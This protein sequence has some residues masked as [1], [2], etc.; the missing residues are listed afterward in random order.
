MAPTVGLGVFKKRQ[1]CCFRLESAPNL[2]TVPD[3]LFRLRH[4]VWLYKLIV[5]A[6]LTKLN[7][8]PMSMR[9]C[10]NC[11]GLFKMESL[12]LVWGCG[13]WDEIRTGLLL[14]RGHGVAQLVEALRYKPEGRGFDS[15]LYHW[16]F[17]LT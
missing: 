8:R 12:Y 9:L 16:N 13:K 1:I 6:D 4:D 2:V 15:R 10:A 3:T 17:S 11:C 5:L 14:D 7:Q